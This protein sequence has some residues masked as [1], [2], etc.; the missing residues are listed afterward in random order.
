MGWACRFSSR[1]ASCPHGAD[2]GGAYSQRLARGG[3]QLVARA[4]YARYFARF[5]ARHQPSGQPRSRIRSI[6]AAACLNRS[7]RARLVH[8]TFYLRRALRRERM[9]YGFRSRPARSGRESVL[10]GNPRIDY[11]PGHQ[12][13][14]GR[15]FDRLATRVYR[16][17]RCHRPE[18]ADHPASIV[19]WQDARYGFLLRVGAVFRWSLSIQRRT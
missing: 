2:C 18:L 17:H 3:R 8:H 7:V 13:I 15:Y 19:F 10:R 11:V 16:G 12:C 14:R 5:R 6:S 9:D 4:R 1:S